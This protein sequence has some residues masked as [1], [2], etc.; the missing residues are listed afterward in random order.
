MDRAVFCLPIPHLTPC[1]S[2]VNSRLKGSKTFTLALHLTVGSMS[3]GISLRRTLKTNN[4]R[5][6]EDGGMEL[7]CFT[8]GVATV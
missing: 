2:A 8:S 5:G 6:E 1:I 4:Q 7:N 3:V